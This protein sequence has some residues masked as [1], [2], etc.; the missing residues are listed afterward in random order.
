MPATTSNRVSEVAS[1][2]LRLSGIGFLFR[3]LLWRDRAAILIYHDP[4]PAVIDAHLRYLA[5]IS[6]L[7]SMPDLWG[8][9]CGVP[10]TAIAIDDGAIGLLDLEPV[11][12]KHRVRPMIYLCT[13]TISA[14]AG[15]WWLAARS[16][17]EV[18]QL[19][20]LD[21]RSRQEALAA[22]GFDQA[23][24]VVPRQALPVEALRS[25][26]E[27]A[28]LGA[29]TRFHPILTRCDPQ[30]CKEEIVAS[31]TEL[32]GAVGMP[33]LDFAYPNGDYSDREVEIVKA[34]GFR[35]ARTC[36]PGWNS[37]DADRFRL[38]AFVIDDNASVDKLAIQLTGISAAAKVLVRRM[39]R[40]LAA[41]RPIRRIL[42]RPPQLDPTRGF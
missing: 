25:M 9:F 41:R 26:R 18:E 16:E 20:T 30:E 13:G 39:R 6:C 15:F 32:E 17:R 11:F 24:E 12:R 38:K 28:D 31:R 34:A 8:A 36:D 22:V 21:N 27:W 40:R 3:K 33:F 14:G 2:I 10:L 7:V 5:R 1:R 23:R 4:K 29:H 42:R 35:S 19:K 37:R